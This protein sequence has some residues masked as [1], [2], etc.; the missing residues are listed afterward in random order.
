MRPVLPSASSHDVGL[1]KVDSFAAQYPAY[2]CPC[3]RFGSSLRSSPHDSGSVWVANPSPCGSFIHY[4]SPVY[5]DARDA[6]PTD[7]EPAFQADRHRLSNLSLTG[8]KACQGESR[9]AFTRHPEAQ[10]KD[11]AQRAAR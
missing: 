2:T 1:P 8:F 10:L 5:P 3:Q 11:L 4:T 6:C 7:S 9:K